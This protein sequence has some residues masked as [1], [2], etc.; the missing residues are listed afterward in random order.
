[1]SANSQDLV[2]PRRVADSRFNLHRPVLIDTRTGKAACPPFDPQYTRE[3]VFEFWPSDVQRLYRAAGL[4]RRTPPNVMK[5][6]QPNR[7]SDQSEAPQIRSPLT[8]VS[9]Q[10]RLSQPQESIPLNANAASDATTLYWF[11]DQTLI[12]QGPPQTTLNWR[13]GKSGEYRLRVSDDQ[14]RSASRG[15][16]VEFVP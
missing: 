12:G 1:M 2:H 13:P 7:I 16:R 8:Q 14:G 9:Y 3:E 15:L 5:N 6:C 11:A 10:L 4:P